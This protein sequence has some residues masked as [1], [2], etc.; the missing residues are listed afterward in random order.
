MLWSGESTIHDH[1]CMCARDCP[2]PQNVSLS[3]LLQPLAQAQ[4]CDLFLSHSAVYCME[5]AHCSNTFQFAQ[6][7]LYAPLAF[8][9]PKATLPQSDQPFRMDTDSASQTEQ[10]YR[11]RIRKVYRWEHKPLNPSKSDNL[12]IHYRPQ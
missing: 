6:D 4:D 9:G 3:F 5:P 1:T 8:A 11:N 7:F 2:L 10:V 12:P